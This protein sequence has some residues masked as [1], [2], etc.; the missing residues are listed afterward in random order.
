MSPS[1]DEWVWVPNVLGG[2]RALRRFRGLARGC[3]RASKSSREMLELARQLGIHPKTLERPRE[4]RGIVTSK[5]GK[6]AGWM[7]HYP[8]AG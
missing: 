1:C 2:Y 5:A 8:Y 6:D 7:W 4:K 3:F